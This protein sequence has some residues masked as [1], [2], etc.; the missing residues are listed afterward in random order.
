MNETKANERKNEMKMNIAKG[1]TPAD[2]GIAA[3]RL[4]SVW[5]R[6]TPEQRGRWASEDRA[7]SARLAKIY[8]K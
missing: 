4:D 6:M 2:N 3:A 8:H 5:A 7:D 1:R